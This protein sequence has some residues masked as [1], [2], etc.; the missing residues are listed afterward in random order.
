MM[1]IFI[2]FTFQMPLSSF[3][4]WP[5]FWLPMSVTKRPKFIGVQWPVKKERPRRGSSTGSVWWPPRCPC[6]WTDLL[7]FLFSRFSI[8]YPQSSQSLQCPPFQPDTLNS[9]CNLVYFHLHGVLSLLTYLLW[10]STFHILHYFVNQ[11][12]TNK[13]TVTFSVCTWSLWF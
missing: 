4:G 3:L 5:V 7:C 6:T 11:N 1:C 10:G 12:V 13:I 9:Q 8:E 2:L